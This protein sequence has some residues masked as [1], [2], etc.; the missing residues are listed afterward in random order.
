M[1]GTAPNETLSNGEGHGSDA[2]QTN[3]PEPSMSIFPGPAL[4][5]DDEQAE[6]NS[7]FDSPNTF[8]GT[9]LTVQTTLSLDDAAIAIIH[10][11]FSRLTVVRALARGAGPAGRTIGGG[12]GRID[13]EESFN[14]ADK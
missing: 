13:E 11:H 4:L 9:E 7:F 2:Q 6:M 10:R 1:S 8:V 3:G 14:I 5:N 12:L